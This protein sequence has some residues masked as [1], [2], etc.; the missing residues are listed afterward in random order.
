MLVELSTTPYSGTGKPEAL[1]FNLEGFWSRRINQKD[2]MI[3]LVEEQE[4]KVLVISLEG[5][6]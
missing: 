4:I 1:K 2:R 6:Y 3:Y 5:H